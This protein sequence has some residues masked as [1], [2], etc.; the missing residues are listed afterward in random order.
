MAQILRPSFPDA[1]VVTVPSS[2]PVRSIVLDESVR[3]EL[4]KEVSGFDASGLRLPGE[5]GPGHGH[6]N[7]HLPGCPPFHKDP[8]DGPPNGGSRAYP[9]FDC[10]EVIPEPT[11]SE[12]LVAGVVVA[13]VVRWYRKVTR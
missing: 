11:V 7:P 6:G 2:P 12:L 8:F 1:S 3:D 4:F 5:H 9:P 13:L 10:P